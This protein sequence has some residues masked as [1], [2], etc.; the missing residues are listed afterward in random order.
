M[1][2]LTPERIREALIACNGVYKHAA[3]L[4]G[5]N[6][7]GFH[8]R[9]ARLQDEGY[10]LP[11]STG[12]ELATLNCY[13]PSPEEFDAARNEIRRQQGLPECEYDHGR[14]N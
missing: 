11:K 1:P 7:A 4:L 12:R 3:E 2:K 9:V 13:M 6:V 10:D 5:V 14:G 8:K